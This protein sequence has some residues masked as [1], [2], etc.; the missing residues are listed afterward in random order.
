MPRAPRDPAY[1]AILERLNAELAASGPANAGPPRFGA[2]LVILGGLLRSGTTLGYQLLAAS[3]SFVYPSNLIARFY[4]R[5]VVGWRV[6]RLMRPFLPPPEAGGPG[7]SSEAGRTEAWY[8]PSELGYFWHA[9]LPFERHHQPGP[10]ALAALDPVP[11]VRELADLQNEDGRPL[12]VKNPILGFV[13]GWLLERI[14]E[15]RMVWISRP[16]LEIAASVHRMRRREM[17]SVDRW[18][19]TR[20]AD[21]G[22]LS[23]RSPEEQIA[24]Q[25]ARL[26][27]AG[28]TAR[29][30]HPERWLEVEYRRLCHDSVGQ[31]ERIAEWVGAPGPRFATPPGP[32]RP[33]VQDV[34]PAVLDR[35]A[36][37]LEAAG[38]R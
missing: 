11:M 8:E 21:V 1:E 6:E 12:V 2:P 35:L 26:L 34:E 30:S 18:W 4:R 3:G 36:G 32:F 7:F 23:R 19:S 25:V 24:G 31:V 10:E 33:S 27:E 9:H 37:F 16:P 28:A 20:P 22:E 5:P 13:Y 15:A 29:E 38:V 17:G 14:P